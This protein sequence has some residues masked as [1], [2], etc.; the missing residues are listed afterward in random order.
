[1]KPMTDVSSYVSSY[2]QK[3]K[4][5]FSK[6]L[7]QLPRHLLKPKTRGDLEAGF[8]DGVRMTIFQLIKDGHLKLE[9]E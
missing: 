7:D 6:Q 8:A 1:M 4:E 3:M 5:E 2:V 9:G